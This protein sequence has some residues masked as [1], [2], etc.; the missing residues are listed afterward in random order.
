MNIKPLRNNVIL[1]PSEAQQENRI[2]LI[3]QSSLDNQG[4]VVAI[5]PE[6]K[7]LKLGDLVRYD[8]QSSR[9]LEQYVMCR[10]L[11]VLCIV[12]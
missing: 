5:G 10:E 11:D 8:T 1:R 7:E 2:G 12:E 6:V 3:I 9:K 4:T